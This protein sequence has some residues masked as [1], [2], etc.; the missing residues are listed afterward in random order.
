MVI[1]PE[2]RKRTAKGESE[3]LKDMLVKGK[4]KGS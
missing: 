1:G 2:S 4:Q 3:V